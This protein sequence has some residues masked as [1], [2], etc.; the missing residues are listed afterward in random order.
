MADL[1]C[2]EMSALKWHCSSFH[3]MRAREREQKEGRIGG[4][5]LPIIPCLLFA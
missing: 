3:Y 5:N 4:M 2:M 1:L